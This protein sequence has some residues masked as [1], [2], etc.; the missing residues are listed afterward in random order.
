MVESVFAM[1][2]DVV[3]TSGDVDGF[4]CYIHVT[5]SENR[6]TGKSAAKNYF[7]AASTILRR[8]RRL[9]FS[10][11]VRLYG[12]H[13]PDSLDRHSHNGYSRSMRHCHLNRLLFSRSVAG[14]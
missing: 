5:E 7:T 11:D 12:G 10:D 14:A 2:S 1:P 13:V 4:D 3:M 8:S 9:F 6:V